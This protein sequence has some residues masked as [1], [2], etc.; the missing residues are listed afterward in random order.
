MEP[1]SLELGV[2]SGLES[3]FRA[4]GSGLRVY[5][6]SALKPGVVP[7]ENCVGFRV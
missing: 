3:G 4:S 1:L 6:A 5:N 7:S 2:G